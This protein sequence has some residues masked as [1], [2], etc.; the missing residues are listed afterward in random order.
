MDDS[1]S[2][3]KCTNKVYLAELMANHQAPAPRS[4]IIRKDNALSTLEDFGYPVVLKIPDGSFSRGVFKASDTPEAQR[5]TDNLF[6]ESD[7]ILAQEFLYTQ[8]DWRIGVLNK[9]PIYACQYHMSNKHWQIVKHSSNG[10]SHHGEHLTLSLDNVPEII[11]KTA[12]KVS[13]L[14]GNGL[15]GVDIK[16]ND[17]KVYVIEVND[18]PNIDHGVE[19]QVLGNSL[20]QHIINEF[21]QRIEQR[22]NHQ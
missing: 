10:K 15:Y 7:L 1:E 19:D 12:E 20:Y 13:S 17:G 6:R 16:E 21:I 11:L 4:A 8:F 3:L 9:K 5:I 14:I 18:N 2:I 22:R